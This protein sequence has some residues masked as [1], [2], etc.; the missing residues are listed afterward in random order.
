[1]R[2]PCW[3]PPAKKDDRK[4]KH[5]K[6]SQWTLIAPIAFEG[7]LL[8]GN[9]AAHRNSAHLKALP[10]SSPSPAPRALPLSLPRSPSPKSPRSAFPFPLSLHSLLQLGREMGIGRCY[11]TEQKT[12]TRLRE[13]ARDFTHSCRHILLDILQRLAWRHD[14]AD[15]DGGSRDILGERSR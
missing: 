10:S 2:C 4:L 6:K 3:I 12:S 7:R 9:F 15:D 11:G 1:M 13:L 8:S 14:G 5:V